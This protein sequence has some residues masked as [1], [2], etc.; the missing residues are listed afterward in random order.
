MPMT[1]KV[2]FF[3]NDKGYGFIAPS[4]GEPDVFVHIKALKGTGMETLAEGQKVSFETTDDNRGRG[5][6]AVNL[7]PVSDEAPNAGQQPPAAQ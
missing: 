5:P 1:G 3:N 6:Q 2:I 7:A 4:N